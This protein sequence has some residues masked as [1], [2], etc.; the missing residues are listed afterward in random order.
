MNAEQ[1]GTQLEAIKH[2]ITL[3]ESNLNAK[4]QILKSRTVPGFG[5]TDHVPI[6]RPDIEQLEREHLQAK[7]ALLNGQ[8]ILG[9]LTPPG[10]KKSQTFRKD[11]YLFP[12]YASLNFRERQI[13]NTHLLEMLNMACQGREN[14]G[15]PK[16]F[17]SIS[18]HDYIR[19][20]N[21]HHR[22]TVARN[23]SAISA[24]LIL[25]ELRKRQ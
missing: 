8:P 9:Q 25:N 3:A 20:F 21:D 6:F 7:E 12:N 11:G 13:F 2:Q 17:S 24:S 22:V 18:G 1:S 4:I 10:A 23:P 15:I 5:L 14:K 16:S 19:Q